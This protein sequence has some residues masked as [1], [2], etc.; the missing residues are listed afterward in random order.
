MARNNDRERS[1]RRAPKD[2]GAASKKKICI[3]CKD[4]VD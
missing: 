4:S 1:K 3:F 2:S